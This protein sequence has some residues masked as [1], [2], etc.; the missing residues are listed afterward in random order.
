MAIVSCKLEEIQKMPDLTDWERVLN[1]KDED[2]DYSDNPT[3]T[4]DDFA[5]ATRGG[6]LLEQPKK[7]ISIYVNP[8]LLS[9]YQKSGKDW[10]TRLSNNFEVFLKQTQNT[11]L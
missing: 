1:M 5:R 6:A 7:R 3:W 10:R 11:A 8:S 4:D 9:H 2:I